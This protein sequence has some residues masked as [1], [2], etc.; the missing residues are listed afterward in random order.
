LENADGGECRDELKSEPLEVPVTTFKRITRSAMKAKAESGVE[1]VNVLEQQGEAVVTVNKDDGKVPVR[2]F[3]RITR[4]A[5]K[6]KVESGEDKED[7]VNVL[8]Q[9]GS[10]A[11][12]ARGKGNGKVL[13]RDFKR[14]TRLA[15]KV[16]DESGEDKVTE[17]E[18]QGAAV[19]SGEVDRTFKRVTRSAAMKA[20][21]EMVTELKQDGSVVAS[22]IN[23]AFPASRNKLELK[24]SKKIVVN[25]KPTTVKELFL[26]GLL[27]GVSVVYIGG[28]KKVRFDMLIVKQ[29]ICI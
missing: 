28:I 5:M 25:K 23:G 18:Q 22:E 12:V 6:E 11:A 27:D 21:E 3:K 10:G 4:S 7:K 19:A 29:E 14:V 2:I 26:T 9:H 8:E 16:K 15:M 17:L 1:T 24:M 13:V 20:G